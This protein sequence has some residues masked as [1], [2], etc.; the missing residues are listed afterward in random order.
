MGEIWKNKWKRRERWEGR[1]IMIR[2]IS[3][4]INKCHM[5]RISPSLVKYQKY[6]KSDQKK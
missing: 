3:K 6:Q 1:N 4:I 2:E 5:R